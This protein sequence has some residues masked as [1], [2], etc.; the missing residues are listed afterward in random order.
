MA[1]NLSSIGSILAII[2]LIL[3]IVLAVIG[4]LAYPI[5]AL[6]ILLALA[7]LLP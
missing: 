5:A 1:L 7:R 6:F 2:V 3:A 4:Q